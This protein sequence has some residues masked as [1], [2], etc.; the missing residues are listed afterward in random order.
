M[1][2]ASPWLLV[3]LVGVP[4]FGCVYVQ[5]QRGR[6][7]MFAAVHMTASVQPRQPGWRRHVP[8]IALFLA[9][10]ILIV[11]CAR[12]QLSV[13]VP[14]EQASIMLATDVSGSMS[15]KDVA[16]DRLTAAKRAVDS[17]LDSVPSRIKVG[18]MAFNQ[19]PTVLQS[20]TVDRAVARAAVEGMTVSGAT[21]SGEAIMTATR[22][23]SAG[24][25][26]EDPPPG[27]IV[28]LSDGESTRGV[29]PI[30]AAREA[31][32]Q[33]VPVYT[34]ALGSGEGTDPATL[35][36]IAEVSVGQSFAVTDAA[37]LTAV[38]EELGS[39]L[40]TKTEKRQVTAWFVG[41][42]LLALFAAGS[43]SLRWFGRLV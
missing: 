18:I 5:R 4:A 19:T 39:R 23:L 30:E 2:F 16:P 25:E 27:A 8:V 43:M 13:A 7:A 34:V 15:T 6:R 26:G 10:A 3:L 17:F 31:G 22:V 21:A 35:R 28:L 11:A 14:V 24:P 42:G 37:G 41:G 38:Y 33:D 36:Q 20:P 32:E 29:D 9:T 1:T 12:P 40:S